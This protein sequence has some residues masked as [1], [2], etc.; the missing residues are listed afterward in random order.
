MQ[1]PSP[2][3]TKTDLLTTYGPFALSLIVILAVAIAWYLHDIDAQTALEFIGAVLAG[4]GL[5]GATRW[6][7]APGLV[8]DLQQFI[9]QLTSHIQTLH[10]QQAQI[11][12]AVAAQ[13]VDQAVTAKVAAV[14]PVSPQ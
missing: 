4:N 13:P 7:A 1:T 10:A 2:A 3:P 8:A 11:Q 12:S 9:G 6:Q 14:K 5:V